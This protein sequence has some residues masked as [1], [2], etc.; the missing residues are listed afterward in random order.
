[1]VVPPVGKFLGESDTFFYDKIGLLFYNNNSLISYYG[2]A[3][4]ISSNSSRYF[5]SIYHLVDLEAKISRF[6]KIFLSQKLD[7]V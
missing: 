3:F 4:D 5:E 2:I 1:M 7:F 6:L